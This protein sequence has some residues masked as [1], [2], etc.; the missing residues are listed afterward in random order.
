M[1]V[2]V[3]QSNYLPWRGYFDF[4]KSVDLF[5]FHD[6]LQYTKNDWRNRNKIK[7]DKG[8]RWITVPVSYHKKDLLISETEICYNSNWA[9]KHFRIL[10]NYYR[11]APF[12]NQMLE[13][14]SDLPTLKEKTISDLNIKLIRR[15]CKYLEIE[16]RCILSSTLHLKGSK[17]E[18]LINLLHEVKA[19][20]Y[21]SG[22]AAL[23]YLDTSLFKKNGFNLE[24]KTYNY[25]TYPQ[26]Y[27][28]FNGNLSI[29]DGIAN[30]GKDILK[31]F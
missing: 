31:H 8:T 20:T 4:I 18:R 28:E 6:D 22:P 24:I 2:G 12:C 17:T 16:T 26:L 19:Q 15:V 9:I 1:R 27:G 29:L 7:T 30:C 23:N 21:V 25:S 13:I 3:I 10:E 11:A 5:V 14:V